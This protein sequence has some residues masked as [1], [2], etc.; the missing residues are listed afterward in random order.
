LEQL[1]LAVSDALSRTFRDVDVEMDV[2]NGKLMAYLA[3]H[4]E[5]LS[6]RYHENRV[7][8]HC[9][10]PQKYLGR[11]TDPAVSIE[12]HVLIPTATTTPSAS[13]GDD[14]V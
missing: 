2:S 1:A 8:I 5:V 9:R 12:D 4:G 7:L 10:I 11:I 13:T 14:S 3:A 6:Q